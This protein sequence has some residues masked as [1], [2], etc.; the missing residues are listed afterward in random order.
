MSQPRNN[1][2]ALQRQIPP[3]QKSS[4]FASAQGAKPSKF[5]PAKTV[6]ASH[7]AAQRGISPLSSFSTPG[8]GKQRPRPPVPSTL[9]AHPSNE[10]IDIST[11]DTTSP[12]SASSVP[13]KR[14]GSD[15][16]PAPPNS[17]KRPRVA[18]PC[19]DRENVFSA[20]RKGK[21]REGR[22]PTPSVHHGLYAAS[23]L[24]E[25]SS[26]LHPQHVLTPRRIVAVSRPFTYKYKVHSDLQDVIFVLSSFVP[27]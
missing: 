17:P 10:A 21:E 15:L 16:A 24:S 12:S 11:S 8:Y 1:L 18:P 3:Q 19:S 4:Y 9:H 23:S 5:K 20:L 26:S 7:A 13:F 25:A 2:E 22:S 27:R 6:C 14:S